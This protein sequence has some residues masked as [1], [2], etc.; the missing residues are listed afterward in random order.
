MLY[1]FSSVTL[2][3]SIHFLLGNSKKEPKDER[4][5]FTKVIKFA[6]YWFLDSGMV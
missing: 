5:F 6:I 4:C 2:L 1:G 3:F